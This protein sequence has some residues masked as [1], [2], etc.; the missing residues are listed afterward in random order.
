MVRVLKLGYYC[1]P[2]VY[3]MGYN[4]R[5]DGEGTETNTAGNDDPAYWKLQPTTRW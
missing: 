1:I 2:L 4:L 3:S 5:P